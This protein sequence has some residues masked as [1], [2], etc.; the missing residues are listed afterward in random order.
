MSADSPS[1]VMSVAEIERRLHEVRQGELHLK[2]ELPPDNAHN[3]VLRYADICRYLQLDQP[4]LLKCFPDL[5][6]HNH[7]LWRARG[8]TA[9]VAAPL[10]A[11]WQ[12][13]LSRFFHGW[14]SGA[15]T[16]AQVHGKWCIVGRHETS[17]LASAPRAQGPTRVLTMRID[18]KTLGLKLER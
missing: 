13:N 12:R 4:N 8:P 3:A 9:T 14:D 16:K 17:P 15:L 10:P 5:P 6:R 18:P 7:R 1:E 2:T 11:A